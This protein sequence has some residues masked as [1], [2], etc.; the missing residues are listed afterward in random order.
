[1][2]FRKH[3]CYLLPPL[4]IAYAI[5]AWRVCCLSTMSEI[6]QPT[7][8]GRYTVA[9]R[10]T[11]F[12]PGVALRLRPAVLQAGLQYPPRH[13]AYLAFK[14]ERKLWVYG[15]DEAQGPWR[16]IKTYPVLAAS[17]EAG[18]KLR[19]GDWQV[20]EGFYQAELLNPN[21]RYHLS[22]RLDYPNAFDRQMAMQAGRTQ[23]GGDIM[24]HGDARST[25]CLA[26]GDE[27]AEDLFILAALAGKAQLRILV[28][29][30]D[31]RRKPVLLPDAAPDWLPGLYASLHTALAEYPLQG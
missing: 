10:V 4:F 8:A 13:L 7:R 11:Q 31:F 29:P 1:M 20:P 22:I 26:M 14:A 3:A 6:K 9:E 5:V 30:W 15:R 27:A 23:L 12:S 21:S 17:G 25:G 18:P 24:I 16:Y 28:G 19:E 2:H